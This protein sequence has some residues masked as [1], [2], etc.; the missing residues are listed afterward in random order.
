[1]R[2]TKEVMS[3]RIH[4]LSRTKIIE[5]FKIYSLTDHEI[6]NKRVNGYL[7]TT[8]LQ[9]TRPIAAQVERARLA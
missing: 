7:M 4:F 2:K 3:N 9:T 5:N 8:R 1:M 6:I